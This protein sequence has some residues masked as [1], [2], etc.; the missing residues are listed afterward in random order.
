M[1]LFKFDLADMAWSNLPFVAEFSIASQP[2]IKGG[3]REAFKAKSNTPIFQGQQWVVKRYLKSAVAIIEEKMQ[4]TEQHT[5]EVVQMHML[6][7][8]CMQKLE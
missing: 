1:K 5:N 4:T 2:F 8:N 3:F 6:A 7:R